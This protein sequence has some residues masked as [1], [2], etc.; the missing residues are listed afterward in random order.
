M[1]L[2]LLPFAAEAAHPE[3]YAVVVGSHRAGPGQV[4]LQY[5]A[6]DA[7]RVRDV[8]VEVGGYPEDH[9]DLLVDPTAA[10][11][12]AALAQVGAE[13]ATAPGET[14]L[15]F[16]YSGHARAQALDLG[17][18]QVELAA[19]KAQLDALPATVKVVVLDACQAGVATQAKGATAVADFSYNSVEGLHTEG[20]AVMASS[21]AT[22]LSQESAA[23][24]GSYF[25][26]NLV[27][28]LRGAADEDHDGRVAMTEAYH[29]A[30][31]RTLIATATSAIGTQHPTLETDLRGHGDLVLTEPATADARLAF[32]PELEGE[33]VIT[34]DASGV[35]V[36]EVMKSAGQRFE[37]AL[38]PGTYTGIL[39]ESGR[40][41]TCPLTLVSGAVA[42]FDATTC[43][44]LDRARV[45]SKGSHPR[46]LET[47]M[48]EASMG[49]ITDR[50]G[51][52]DVALQS[53]GVEAQ[54]G[55]LYGS[56]LVGALYTGSIVV[57]VK[58]LIGV[59]ATI[60]NLGSGRGATLECMSCDN[61]VEWFTFRTGVGPRLQKPLWHDR[62]VPY[63]QLVVGPAFG[64]LYQTF[65]AP[66]V[67]H[68][69]APS[70][71]VDAGLQLHPDLGGHRVLGVFAEA[72]YAWAPALE[73][74]DGSRRNAGGFTFQLGLRLGS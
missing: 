26:E 60:G 32:G 43:T 40:A 2:A 45:A 24:G 51:P 35:A 74:L 20:M 49:A 52:F 12:Q 68:T 38:V 44:T 29:Y 54:P 48:I 36:A 33:I 23:L 14:V 30:Y 65:E 9:V 13:L 53:R 11:L 47:V 66:V 63:E 6:A 41:S 58:P 55:A 56:R 10:E 57:G 72:G 3:A 4:P 64:Q 16:Y 18:E 37:L 17:A 73:D 22:E 19:L 69:V 46:R 7:G 25:T 15:V 1:W 5:A 50:D 27:T 8:L 28:G 34:Q 70:L 42:T 39:R 21:T 31:D 62:L 67:V 71:A 59:V 61:A